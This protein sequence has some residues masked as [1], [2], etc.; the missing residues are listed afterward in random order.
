MNNLKTMK[1]IFCIFTLAALF[2]SAAFAG[3]PM[4]SA[5]F[6]DAYNFRHQLNPAFPAARDYFALPALG[7]MNVG[8][9]SNMGIKTF[10]YPT[11]NGQLT[12]FMNNSVSS[13]EFLGNL[14]KN[15]M[16]NMDIST[17]LLSVGFWNKKLGG[18]S[19]VELNFKCNASV[20]L[21]RSLF[22][23]VKNVGSEQ[24]YD[25]SNLGASA[26]AYLEI[27]LGHSRK[28]TDNLTVGAKLK[29]LMGA[30]NAKVNVD[31]M[32]LDMTAD[33]WKV[34]ANG[35]IKAAAGGMLYVPTF[36]ET[37]NAVSGQRPDQIDMDGISFDPAAAFRER[38]ISAFLGGYGAAI[39]LGASYEIF[40][41]LTVS[42]AV[43]DLGFI[44]WKDAINAT[45]GETAWSFKGFEN[46]SFDENSE[47]HIGKQFDK[48]GDELVDMLAFYKKENSKSTDMLAATIHAGAQYTMPFWEGM[49]VGALLTSRIQ[50]THSW[51]EGRLSVNFA[52]GNVF[53]LSGS[54]AYSNF[55]SSFGAAFNLHC[56]AVSF[57]LGTDTIPGRFS[58]PMNDC[59]SLKLP[60]GKVRLG[61]NCGLVFNVSKRKDK[62]I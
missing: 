51:T 22:S 24:H 59:M 6:L 16:L 15:N 13:S 50:G 8:L 14:H 37:G 9:Q 21:P 23:F 62:A 30:L 46:V 39:D 36:A 18:F 58:A 29:F 55:G 20:N 38:G 40:D 28:I 10:L 42:A 57:Y 2:S 54:Y 31:N 60:V 26:K 43:L 52:F 4:R 49:S 35:Y 12:T 56:N 25:I 45:T 27:S 47:N 61:V 34:N 1:K 53:A 44:S 19:S 32:T 48:L 3:E 11:A 33:E 7:Y 5:Y 41:G 17:S